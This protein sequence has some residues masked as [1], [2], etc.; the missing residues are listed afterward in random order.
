MIEFYDDYVVFYD[1]KIVDECF[2]V[3]WEDILLWR[4]QACKGSLDEI[5]IVLKDER[6]IRFQVFSKSKIL[7][8]FRKYAPNSDEIKN[9]EFINVK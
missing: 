4:Y 6:H 9:R 7:K 1:E 5:E 8:Y 2:I 3:F